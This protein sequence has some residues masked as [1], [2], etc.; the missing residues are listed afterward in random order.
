MRYHF[1]GHASDFKKQPRNIGMPQCSSLGEH[2][3]FCGLGVHQDLPIAGDPNPQSP[4]VSL[5]AQAITVLKL[6]NT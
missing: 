2:D 1:K 3:F 4:S 6:T 5:S